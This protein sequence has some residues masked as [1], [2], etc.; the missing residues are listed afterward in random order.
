M[1]VYMGIMAIHQEEKI[2]KLK[3]ELASYKA[4]PS[5]IKDPITKPITEDPI[6]TDPVKIGEVMPNGMINL[7]SAT[8]LDFVKMEGQVQGKSFQMNVTKNPN[9]EN[10]TID[11][12]VGGQKVV[13][14]AITKINPD[15]VEI[16]GQVEDK[17]LQITI[18]V[19]NHHD[20]G[21][22]VKM[23]GTFDGDHLEMSCD[24]NGCTANAAM[25][26]YRLLLEGLNRH[27][28]YQNC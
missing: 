9:T 25:Q 7:G 26:K 17:V 13:D 23:D 27:I 5:T 4:D 15:T 11:A 10:V 21:P 14:I 22:D 12:S 2:A 20:D 8:P 1:V 24:R 16:T 6:T 18:T 19:E 3:N 28:D